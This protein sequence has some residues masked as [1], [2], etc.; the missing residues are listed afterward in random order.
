M[1]F[2]LRRVN[3]TFRNHLLN[4]PALGEIDKLQ[5]GQSFDY[6]WAEYSSGIA[7][8]DDTAFMSQLQSQ[9]CQM[10]DLP[11]EWFK[12]KRVIDIGCGAGRFTYGML[13]MGAYVTACDQSDAGLKKTAKLCA[14]HS[15][16]LTTKQINLLKWD[17]VGDFDLVFCFGVV[18][19]T[20][21]T[22]SAIKNAALKVKPGG[23]L[24]LMIYGFPENLNAF[25]ELI[26]YEEVRQTVRILSFEE[27][28]KYL[29]DRFGPYYA[30]GWFDAVS[31]QINDLL[32]F[33]ET[34]DFLTTQGF[35]RI[36]RTM[37]GRNHHLVGDKLAK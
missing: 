23:R 27:K 24:F 15:D 29:I 5:T 35:S 26:S 4:D 2:E 11:T 37:P 10:T 17:E 8:S 34:A 31:P 20:G 22:Y 30:H 16:R 6:Q 19:H 36:K 21:N 33:E 28:K 7:M 3:E 1:L 12:G 32:T 13:S 14:E 18:H 25:E 9:I